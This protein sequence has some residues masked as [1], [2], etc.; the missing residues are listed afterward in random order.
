M[1]SAS[2]RAIVLS[3][4]V[5]G[6]ALGDAER[7]L[8][9]LRGR[10]VRGADWGDYQ[11]AEHALAQNLGQPRRALRALEALENARSST[12]PGLA[13]RMR[14]LD[15]LYGTGDS[16]E[17]AAVAATLAPGSRPSTP[18]QPGAASVLQHEAWCVRGQWDAWQAAVNPTK[19][20]VRAERPK[21]GE[22]TTE[23]DQENST[24]LC[25]ALTAA[26]R[27]VRLRYPDAVDTLS[28]LDSL[29]TFG[30]PLGSLRPYVHLAM[31]RLYAELGNYD[32]AVNM[33]RRR[34]N[35]EDWPHYLA[36]QRLEEGR[37]LATRGDSVGAASAFAHYLAL[38][39]DPEPR[40]RPEVDA[41][42]A[43]LAGLRGR[44]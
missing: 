40:V 18:Q 1:P 42:R 12:E 11:L 15:A 22:S 39:D 14:V 16:V 34:T 10:V 3:S 44:R 33:F 36:S 32:R 7:A 24:S 19:D 23:V 9:V 43:E 26:I 6:I 41:V 38:R 29:I 17:A 28:R 21:H 35:M 2:L 5:N 37:L 8:A 31:G 4:Q 25:G 13:A 27:A 20:L 30:P